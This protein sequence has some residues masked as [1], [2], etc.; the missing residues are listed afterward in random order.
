[1]GYVK[2]ISYKTFCHFNKK[3]IKNTETTNE[4]KMYQ[5]NYGSINNG[6]Y[7]YIFNDWM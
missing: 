1:M 7:I 4:K 5:Y 2:G 3:V 6:I